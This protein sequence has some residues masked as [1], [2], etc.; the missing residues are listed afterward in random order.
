MVEID[1]EKSICYFSNLLP[2]ENL[3]N[4]I[5]HIMYMYRSIQLRV[6][7]LARDLTPTAIGGGGSKL[8]L[9][10]IHSE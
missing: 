10:E 9:H 4:I 6:T 8:C 1:G 5:N 3:Q 2:S 7:L